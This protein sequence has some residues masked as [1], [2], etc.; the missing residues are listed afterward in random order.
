MSECSDTTA[1]A[2]PSPDE[3]LSYA[4]QAIVKACCDVE[5]I[6]HLSA[7]A[8]E[9]LPNSTD[10]DRSVAVLKGQ[11]SL[12]LDLLEYLQSADRQLRRP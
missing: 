11:A 3:A 8:Y 1:P 4:R 5:A 9:L 10:E 6:W 12:C 7:V 2:W